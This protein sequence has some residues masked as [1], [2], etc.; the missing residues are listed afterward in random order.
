MPVLNVNEREAIRTTLETNLRR[1]VPLHLY[2]SSGGGLYIPGRECRDCEQF[3]ALLNEII[4][5]CPKM[6]LKTTDYFSNQTLAVEDNIARIPTLLI[7]NSPSKLR[8][9][10]LPLENQLSVLIQAFIGAS[11]IRSPL[12]LDTRRQLR[13]LKDDVHVQVF[14]SRTCRFSPQTA[15]LACMMALESPNLTTEVLQIESLSD[16]PALYSIRG[17]PKIVINGRVHFTGALNENAL[18]MQILRASGLES[19]GTEQ[20]VDYSNEVTPL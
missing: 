8:Y 16:V 10:G 1:N 6:S 17:V 9:V 11:G 15:I 12:K 4:T 14:V 7:G 18:L 2:T 3:E 20:I 19:A 5:E 13:R